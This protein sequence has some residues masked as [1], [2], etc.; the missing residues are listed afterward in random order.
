MRRLTIK[1][2]SKPYLYGL[3]AGLLISLV[4]R[5]LDLMPLIQKILAAI[6]ALL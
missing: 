5:E 2:S 1:R 6:I 3:L 4:A